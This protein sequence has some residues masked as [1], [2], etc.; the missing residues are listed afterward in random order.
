MSFLITGASGYLGEEF[1]N[2][3]L[4]DYSG[5]KATENKI[6]LLLRNRSFEIL[7]R[8]FKENSQVVCI[9]GDLRNP[10]VF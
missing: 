5:P 1:L 10:D 9:K 6:Y 2:E 7:S 8:R 3:I 4:A